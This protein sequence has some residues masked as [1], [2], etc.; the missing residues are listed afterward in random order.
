MKKRS[1]E[2]AFSEAAPDYDTWV[3]QA[4]PAYDE[5]FSVAVECIPF[6]H[7]RPLDIVDLGAGSGLFSRRVHS[8]YP[9]AAFTLVD[10]SRDMLD[11]ARKRFEQ[12]TAS[13]TFV[14]QRLEDFAEPER[15]D[16]VISSLAIH[17]LE[18]ADKR[19]LFKRIF[20]A[21]RP[22]GAFIN[23]DQIKGN[24]PF[25]RLYWETWLARVR[26]AG[27][28]EDQIQTSIRR[29]RE[30]DRDASLSDQL[31]W[32]NEAGFAVDCIYKHYFV[33]VLLA[34]KNDS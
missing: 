29:R 25:D 16:V 23:V 32:L 28:S 20:T 10:A 15:F 26:A 7:D 9:Q 22:G 34:L 13:F 14:E 1:V 17:H 3:K 18:D 11:L 12:R 33:A 5:L 31:K 6:A 8:A 21:L 2:Q 27:A 4:L 19:S 30:F 24:P